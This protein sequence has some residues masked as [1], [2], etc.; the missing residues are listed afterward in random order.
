M[1]TY[2]ESAEGVTISHNRALKELESHG[3]VLTNENIGDGLS[4]QEFYTALGHR[5]SYSATDV[6]DYL[7]Y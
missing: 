1:T 3:I 6:L 2:Y 7:G 5:E 4:V